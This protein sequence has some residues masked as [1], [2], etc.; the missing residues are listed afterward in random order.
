[1]VQLAVGV[2]VLELLAVHHQHG[3]GPRTNHR[4][5]GLGGGDVAATAGRQQGESGCSQH[6][7]S[8]TDGHRA[9]PRVAA[10][11]FTVHVVS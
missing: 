2:R 8:N 6:A 3:L 7:D 9:Q 10:Q 1:M 5:S 11:E 4:L